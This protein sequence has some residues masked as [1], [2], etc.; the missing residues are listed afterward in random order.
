MALPPLPCPIAVIGMGCRLPG[1]SNNPE[2]LWEMLS[3]GLSGWGKIPADR[4]NSK[5]FYHPSPDAKE[6]Y[7]AESGYFLKEDIAA[8][9]ATFF[10]IMSYE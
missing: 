5:S 7:N 3:A 1:G 9:D 8:F 4:W 10:G 6:G 2:K